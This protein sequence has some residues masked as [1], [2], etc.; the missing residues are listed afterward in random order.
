[1]TRDEA[2][3]CFKKR[4]PT[5]YGAHEFIDFCIEV[6]MLEVEEEMTDAQKAVAVLKKKG[7]G[8]SAKFVI[9]KL[10]QSGFKIVE[11]KK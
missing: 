3:A 7:I 4:V 5:M 6:G 1:M 2:I 11:M 10:E 9:N 8:V